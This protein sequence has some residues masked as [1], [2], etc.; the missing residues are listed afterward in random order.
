M[1][2]PTRHGRAQAGEEGT[3]LNLKAGS[4]KGHSCMGEVHPVPGWASSRA[5]VGLIPCSHEGT[6]RRNELRRRSPILRRDA[7]ELRA[8]IHG[9]GSMRPC[10]F[11]PGGESLG[12]LG[13]RVDPSGHEPR[14]P[15]SVTRRSG[16]QGTWPWFRSS[17]TH[18][19]CSKAAE[20]GIDVDF[21]KIDKT[22][23]PLPATSQ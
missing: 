22:A 19:T 13:M 23:E 8:C 4:M 11:I 9:H 3:G 2:A 6:W 16:S 5:W 15:T 1:D 17:S 7:S 10:A 12:P 18:E 14:R 21:S 20:H